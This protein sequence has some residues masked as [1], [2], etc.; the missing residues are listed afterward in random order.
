MQSLT[1]CSQRQLGARLDFAPANEAPVLLH[2]SAE[3]NLL[4]LLG[5]H[6]RGE[7]Q[8]CQ[9]PLHLQ[10]PWRVSGCLLAGG[11]C[12]AARH[13]GIKS[14]NWHNQR[15]HRNYACA[16]AHGADVEHEHLVLHQLGH[17]ALLLAALRTCAAVLAIGCRRPSAQLLVNASACLM[18]VLHACY[19]AATPLFHVL[20]REA[21]PQC[22]RP[23]GVAAGRS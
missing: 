12:A 20:T 4:A 14:M 19:V 22:A 8:L 23:A 16:S 7:L 17:L 13:D 11:C 2:S 3:G 1:R 18:Q 10:Q 21:P 6:W 9:I 5:A 15:T